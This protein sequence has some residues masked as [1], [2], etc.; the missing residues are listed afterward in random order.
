MRSAGDARKL[1]DLGWTPPQEFS[2][3]AADGETTLWGTMYFPAGF[4]PDERY[5]VVEYTYGG[6]QWAVCPHAFSTWWSTAPTA[7][8]QL[9]YV[10][11]VL[12]ARGTP[13]RSKAFHDVVYRSWA[14]HLADD[15]AEALKQLAERHSFIDLSRGAG[16]TG[17]SWGGYTTFRLLAD[18][19]DVYSAGVA[20]APGSTRT[21]A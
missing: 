6:P 5:P 16:V 2:V 14:G 11:V 4:D 1:T 17:H 12:D 15:H 10:T 8:A 3:L 21:G 9:G 18:R 20:F 7:L 19:P 13:E